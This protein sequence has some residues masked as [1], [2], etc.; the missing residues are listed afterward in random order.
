M[1]F[2]KSRWFRGRYSCD[3]QI[4]KINREKRKDLCNGVKSYVKGEVVINCVGGGMKG[5]D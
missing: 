1:R 3:G 4:S 5:G 2:P